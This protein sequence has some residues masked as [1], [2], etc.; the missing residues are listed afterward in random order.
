MP[1][2]APGSRKHVSKPS[3]FNCDRRP[4]PSRSTSGRSLILQRRGWGIAREEIA[5]VARRSLDDDRGGCRP[6]HGRRAWSGALMGLVIGA[7]HRSLR[8]IALFGF[9]VLLGGSAWGALSIPTAAQGDRRPSMAPRCLAHSPQL[10]HLR[11]RIYAFPEPAGQRR[12]LLVWTRERH[13]SHRGTER[14]FV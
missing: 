5:N 3:L 8:T 9:G 6:G 2:D 4:L 1:T 10:S 7:R 13:R 11:L 12:Q 14:E